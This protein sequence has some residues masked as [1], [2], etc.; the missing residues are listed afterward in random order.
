MVPEFRAQY[1]VQK[2][3]RPLCTEVERSGKTPVRGVECCRMGPEGQLRFKWLRQHFCKEKY[4][5]QTEAQ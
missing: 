2:K 5:Y 1:G 3:R 4:T